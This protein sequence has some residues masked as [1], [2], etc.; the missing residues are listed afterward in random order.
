MKPVCNCCCDWCPLSKTMTRSLVVWLE[1]ALDVV[2]T[3]P[4]MPDHL[5]QSLA[6]TAIFES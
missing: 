2:G 5:I 4:P 6:Q 3:V 1:R